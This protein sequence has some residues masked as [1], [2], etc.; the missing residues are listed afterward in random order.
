[1]LDD[2]RRITPEAFLCALRTLRP[3]ELCNPDVSSAIEFVRQTVVRMSA[4]EFD[5]WR[6]AKMYPK[7]VLVGSDSKV[8]Q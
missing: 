8:K 6:Q 2:V 7:D 5:E 1:M 3:W 4:D